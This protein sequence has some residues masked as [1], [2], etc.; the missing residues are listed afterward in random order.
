MTLTDILALAFMGVGMGFSL[1]GASTA[2]L[3]S[4]VIIAIYGSK[5]GNGIIFLPFFFANLVFAWQHRKRFNKTVVRKLL[6]AALCGMGA[7]ALCANQIPEQMF[8]NLIGCAI[9]FSSLLF[10]IKQYETRLTSLGWLF[11]VLGGASS[12]L[13][14]VSGPIFNVFFLSFKPDEDTFVSTRSI[15]FAVLN[16]IKF[17]MYLTVF[18]NINS[19]TLTRGLF[20]MPFILVGIKLAAWLFARI[21]PETFVRLVVLLG[22][23]AA[24]NLFSW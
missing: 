17:V 14:N 5:L 2:V 4:P 1:M 24:F 8:R 19:Y 3:F 10:F 22:L 15:F 16:G 6:P 18:G 7:A 20:A 13:A 21:R 23:G 11:G 12:Y 9:V